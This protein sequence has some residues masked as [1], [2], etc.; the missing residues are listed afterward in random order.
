MKIIVYCAMR[1]TI[2]EYSQ[3]LVDG[4]MMYVFTTGET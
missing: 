3:P 2:W 4:M 1:Y